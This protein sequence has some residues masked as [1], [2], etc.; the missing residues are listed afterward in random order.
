MCATSSFA[1][2]VKYEV[3]V[4]L[5]SVK[6]VRGTLQ[7]VSEDGIAVQDFQGR[8]YI[9]KAKNIVKIKVRRKGLTVVE[10]LGTGSAIGL[11]A[12]VAIFFSNDTFDD[13]GQKALGTALLT[14]VGAVG[15]TLGGIV[16]EALNTKLILHINLDTQKFRK[17]YL[18]LEKYSKSAYL[19]NPTSITK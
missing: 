18:K 14:G 10:G 1:Q 7:K 4:V 17:E 15:G 11:S 12:G 19:D 8:Y 9:F 3:K 5:D 16:G 2:Y 13:F 6:N